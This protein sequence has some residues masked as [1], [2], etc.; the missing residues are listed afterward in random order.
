MN[1]AHPHHKKAFALCV[2]GALALVAALAALGLVLH[3]PVAGSAAADVASGSGA[4]EAGPDHCL[5]YGK[6]CLTALLRGR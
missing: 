2:A 5:I 3:T 4:P 6:Y 1:R